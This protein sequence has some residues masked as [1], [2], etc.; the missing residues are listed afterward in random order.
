MNNDIYT[1]ESEFVEVRTDASTQVFELEEYRLVIST[2][3]EGK[4]YSS[5]DVDLWL[6]NR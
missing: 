2:N 4:I 6:T 5:E 3:I 1:L